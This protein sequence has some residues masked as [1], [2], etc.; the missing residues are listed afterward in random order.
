MI[1][2]RRIAAAWIYGSLARGS[3]DDLSDIDVRVVV[4]ERD[5]ESALAGRY[6]FVAEV[7]E[8]ILVLEAPQNRPPGGAYNMV[9]YAG[10]QGPH[11]IDWTWSSSATTRIP[12]GV[13]TLHNRGQLAESGEPMEFA[14]QSV[15]ERDRP[16][17][18]RQALHGFWSMLLVVA[19][20][21]ARSPY[22][23]RMGLL[24]WTVPQ[25]REAQQFAGFEP[26]PSFE[27]I[28]PHP[29]PADKMSALRT[30]AAEAS[31][32]TSALAQ[33]GVIAPVQIVTHAARY[34]D[35]VEAVMSATKRPEGT[36]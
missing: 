17:E 5:F 24:Q 21:A 23:T 14:Y 12:T 10:A 25:L 36:A 11:P 35:L 8:P 26:G 13:T 1:E 16:E 19:K 30:L 3:E 33:R 29:E 22:E 7:G 15:P 31:A 4:D 34:F 2:D 18:I 9:W 28:A 32:L 27:Q 20:Y 6:D